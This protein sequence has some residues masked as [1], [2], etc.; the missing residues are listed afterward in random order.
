MFLVVGGVIG[1]LL[2]RYVRGRVERLGTFHAVFVTNTVLAP[3]LSHLDLTEPLTGATYARVDALVRERLLADGRDVRVKIWRRDGT[4]VYSDASELVGRTFPDE[5][6]ALRDAAAGKVES[7]IADLS[8]PEYAS[9]RGVADKLFFTYVPIRDRPGGPVVAVAEIYQDYSVIQGDIDGL[10]HGMTLTFGLGL[11]LLYAALLPIAYRASR[12]LRDRNAQLNELLA[13]EQQSVAELRDL[14]HKKDDFVAAVSHELRTPLTSIIGYLSTLK[15]TGPGDNP[16]I[17]SE[18]LDAA[19]GQAQRLLRQIT[20]LLSA[21]H[22]DEGS[23]PIVLERIDFAQ[24]ARQVIEGAPGA[25]QRVRLE[26]SPDA[27]LVVTDR[28][29]IDEILTNLLDNA[30]KYSP[31]D[32]VVEVGT[33]AAGGEFTFWVEDRGIG[34]DP[35]EQSA[36]FDR[37]HQVDQS[38]T[39]RFGGVGLGLHLTKI[40]VEDLGGRID[41]DSEPGRGSTFTVTIPVTQI[42]ADGPAPDP[43]LR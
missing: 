30:L 23:R 40:L 11:L 42:L 31:D 1:T 27:A 9:E 5:R 38:A 26:I 18:F 16:Q 20:N 43:A 25:P 32:S 29:R 8:A 12:D 21:A 3:A 33:G 39:R 34:I 6:P 4:V 15:Q 7:G 24:L 19:E 41:V 10:F 28:G 37:F 2:V 13:R 17:R 35:A 36:V 14:S 22:L